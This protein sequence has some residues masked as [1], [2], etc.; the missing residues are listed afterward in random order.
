MNQ[1]ENLARV[2]CNL[3]EPIA[4]YVRELGRDGIFL[5]QDL[6][7]HLLSLGL[8]FAPDSPSRILRQ[9]RR[10]GAI[11]YRVISRSNS[12]YQVL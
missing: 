1:D 5:M 3:A 10:N 12:T 4:D 11:N 2:Y 8:R 9:L 6:R 7:D